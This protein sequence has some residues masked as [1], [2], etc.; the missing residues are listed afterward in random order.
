MRKIKIMDSNY[1]TALRSYGPCVCPINVSDEQLRKIIAEGHKV[2]ECDNMGRYNSIDRRNWNDPDR[3]KAPTKIVAKADPVVNSNPFGEE[4]V[5]ESEPATFSGY[6]KNTVQPAESMPASA[7]E[8]PVALSRKQ[9]KE[10]RKQQQEAA[11]AK[12]AAEAEVAKETAETTET[13]TEETAEVSE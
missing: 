10:L 4:V 7:A 12:A 6:T 2:L 3:F 9:R 13:A 11:A 5:T 8:S 1:I